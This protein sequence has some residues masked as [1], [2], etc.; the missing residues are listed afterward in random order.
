MADQVT[1]T[2]YKEQSDLVLRYIIGNNVVEQLYEY[3]GCKSITG[4]SACCEIVSI[5]ESAQFSVSDCRAQMYNG[6][7]NMAGQQR[8][9]TACFQRLAPKAPY[10]HCAS[11][12]LNIGLL[13]ACDI[14]DKQCMLNVIRTVGILFKLSPKKQ[15]LLQEC[16][17]YFNRSAVENGTKIMYLRKVNLLCDTR[18]F[19]PCSE[20]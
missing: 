16:V 20:L 9:C 18:I 7:G 19:V 17:E 4:E 11:H 8:G 13:K 5:L 1:N 6:A 10:F 2:S 12:D 3:L 14:R 15:V